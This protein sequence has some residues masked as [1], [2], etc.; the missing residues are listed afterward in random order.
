[1]LNLLLVP[2]ELY[3]DTELNS[4]L[5][6]S[7]ISCYE[8]NKKLNSSSW[9]L[10]LSWCFCEDKWAKRWLTESLSVTSSPWVHS[11]MAV[12]SICCFSSNSFLISSAEIWWNGRLYSSQCLL[13]ES[14]PEGTALSC[15]LSLNRNNLSPVSAYIFFLGL[16]V[17]LKLIKYQ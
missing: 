15:P 14:L 5:T 12:Y 7:V 17:S 1:M 9:C 16:V 3:A 4:K 11:S 13:M 2:E 8:W 10:D 6:I